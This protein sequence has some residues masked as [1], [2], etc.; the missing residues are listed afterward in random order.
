MRKPIVLVGLL[1]GTLW[2]PDS[3][4]QQSHDLTD[5]SL[6]ELMRAEM[7]SPPPANGLEGGR[8]RP[9]RLAWRF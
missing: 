2:Q 6:E 1:A 3:L 5:I 9:G 4:A 7:Y 8:S